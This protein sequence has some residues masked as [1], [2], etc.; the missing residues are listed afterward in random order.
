[1]DLLEFVLDK[2]EQYFRKLDDLDIKSFRQQI[3]EKLAKENI[4]L[5]RTEKS[6]S[7]IKKKHV[8]V[9]VEALNQK[10]KKGAEKAL[11]DFLKLACLRKGY[12][13]IFKIP[14]GDLEDYQNMKTLKDTKVQTKYTGD[15][16]S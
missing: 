3:K 7:K 2:V 13:I 14:K 8:K 16:H 15:L 6:G 11:K 5:I 12:K 4:G 10:N 1:M 9:V